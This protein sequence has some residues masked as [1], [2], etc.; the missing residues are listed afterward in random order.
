MD[1]DTYANAD[2]A[3]YAA[4]TFVNVKLD[5]DKEPQLGNT[6]GLTAYPTA[7]ILSPDGELL[8]RIEGFEEPKPFLERLEKISESHE[9]LAHLN[10]IEKK[11]LTHLK[12]IANLY[13]HLQLP[14]KAAEAFRSVID[15]SDADRQTRADSYVAL[16]D[17]GTNGLRSTTF[18]GV[19]WLQKLLDEVKAFDPDNASDLLDD[20]AF[21]EVSILAMQRKDE[22][23]IQAAQDAY[24][25]FSKSDRADC[26]LFQIAMAHRR[27]GRKDESLQTLR[28]L[29]EKHP[30]TTCGKRAAEMIPKDK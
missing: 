19:A 26:L 28:A 27:A 7:F 9:R 30:N 21:A 18:D 14:A 12:E 16:L 11:G 24:E 22:R 25:K 6:L 10:K 8:G 13:Y 29:A 20:A 1:T 2:V 5:G 23:V 3:A 15:H 4:K 17:I